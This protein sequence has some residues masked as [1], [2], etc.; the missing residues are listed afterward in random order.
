MFFSNKNRGIKS[1]G[2][3]SESQEMYH[4]FATSFL[5]WTGSARMPAISAAC[6]VRSS[7]SLSSAWSVAFGFRIA[8][9]SAISE[10]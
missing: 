8:A 7:A 10:A 4:F 3:G 9:H 1:V 2:L 6:P 5:A